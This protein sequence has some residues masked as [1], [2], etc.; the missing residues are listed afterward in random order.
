MNEWIDLKCL[1]QLQLTFFRSNYEMGT[2]MTVW[3]SLI[4]IINLTPN[5][6]ITPN[7]SFQSHILQSNLSKDGCMRQA[8]ELKKDPRFSIKSN[9]EVLEYFQN[10]D[11]VLGDHRYYCYPTRSKWKIEFFDS[12][13]CFRALNALCKNCIFWLTI[14]WP[15]WN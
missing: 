7:A 5:V 14:C 15:L 4:M 2:H 13:L 6:G 11:E 12:A 3:Y 9:G 8:Y 1:V 10:S